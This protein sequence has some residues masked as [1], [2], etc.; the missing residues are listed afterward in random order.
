MA[1]SDRCSGLKICPVSSNLQTTPKGP[2]ATLVSAALQR[3]TNHSVDAV[4]LDRGLGPMAGGVSRPLV[5]GESSLV[6]NGLSRPSVMSAAPKEHPRS[7]VQVVPPAAGDGGQDGGSDAGTGPQDFD[8]AST[9]CL[10]VRSTTCSTLF[11][12]SLISVSKAS[13]LLTILPAC[14]YP[15]QRQRLPAALPHRYCVLPSPTSFGYPDFGS[16]YQGL[17]TRQHYRIGGLEIAEK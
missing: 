8:G 5:R 6:Q 10:L 13:G 14:C 4:A 7:D 2:S 17:T 9:F 12:A 1:F 11:R 3:M 16:A 15:D